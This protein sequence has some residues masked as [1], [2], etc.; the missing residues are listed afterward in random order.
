MLEKDIDTLARTIY[1]EARGE[2]HHGKIAVGWVVKNRAE[3]GGWWGNEINEC[4]TK[5]WQFSCW[6]ENDPNREKL[7]NVT[8]D[9]I[10]F[11]KCYNAALDVILGQ[12]PDPV[13]GSTHYHTSAISPNWSEGKNP[14]CS[15][16]THVFYNDVE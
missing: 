6:N 8:L 16:G 2:S 7:L 13:D 1:G 12:E 4:C 15:I 5:P 3:K 11:A 10:D 14:V 9:D